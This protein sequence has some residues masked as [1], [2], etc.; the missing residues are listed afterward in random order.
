[1]ITNLQI[2]ISILTPW[3][4]TTSLFVALNRRG[5]VLPLDAVIF[6]R[7]GVLGADFG[8]F[9]DTIVPNASKIGGPQLGFL[10]GKVQVA[11]QPGQFLLPSKLKNRFVVKSFID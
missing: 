6:C 4:P 11:G 9:W 3:T 8:P 10:L 1:M 7:F 5:D 2:K